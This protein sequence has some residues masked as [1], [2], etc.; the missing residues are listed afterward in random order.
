MKKYEPLRAYLANQ[1][2]DIGEVKLTFSAIEAII[3]AS[4]PA[5]AAMHREWWSNEANP[6][7]GQKAAWRDAGWRTEKILLAQGVVV[8]RRADSI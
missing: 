8:F 2:P 5:S 3:R 4:L 6:K 1:A 7:H